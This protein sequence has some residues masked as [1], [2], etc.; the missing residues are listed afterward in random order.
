MGVERLGTLPDTVPWRKVV[1]RIAE[2][3][4]VAAV[5]TATTQAAKRG[6]ELAHSDEGLV[7]CTWLLTRVVLAARQAEFADA[8][9]ENGI[10]VPYDPDLFDIVGGFSDAVDH[11]LHK[12]AGRTDL[13][14][15]AQLAAV[16][17]LTQ[18][19]GQR[20]TGLFEPEAGDV[21]EAAHE[22]STR[23]GFATLAH[24]FFARFAQRFLTYHLGR[25]L[26]NHVGGNG[27]FATPEEH[28]EF[29]EQLG[30]HCRE[31]AG[32]MREFAG[33]WYSKHNFLG[34]I[35]PFKARGFVNHCLDKLHE[36]LTIRGERD[37]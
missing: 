13:S 4:D 18:L 30:I 21:Q 37:G 14:E 34:G 25:E 33:D 3:G 36:Q 1:A 29:V 20:S 35:T 7:Y 16:E 5:A 19:L 24:D 12:T 6:L 15:M 22:L 31:V 23:G 28:T 10:S 2:Q 32:V 9:N 8:L 27:R 17:S 26:S 11:R